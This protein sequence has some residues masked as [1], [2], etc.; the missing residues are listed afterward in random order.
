MRVRRGN[1]G[2][3]WTKVVSGSSQS[4]QVQRSV[5]RSISQAASIAQAQAQ[6]QAQLRSQPMPRSALGLKTSDV[7]DTLSQNI[8]FLRRGWNSRRLTV[9][10]QPVLLVDAPYTSVWQ[11]QNLGSQ[12]L[13]E[14][15]WGSVTTV[16]AAGSNISNPLDIS[17]FSN[18]DLYLSVTSV[19]G[20]WDFDLWTL[21]MADASW[22][23]IGTFFPGI[24]APTSQWLPIIP[25]LVGPVYLYS[26]GAV[27]AMSWNPTAPGV[28]TFSLG[29]LLKNPLVASG[30]ILYLGSNNGMSVVSGYGLPQG[31]GQILVIDEGTQVFGISGGGDIAVDVMQF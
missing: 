15:P 5:S 16:N 18:L 9:G 2:Q 6:T 29:Y 3:D 23:N 7:F 13:M 14:G 8:L 25:A 11:I 17:G 19:T 22:I 26:V 27:V 28:I 12:S 1:F 21:S 20:S 24:V 31:S 10:N 4:G 30:S